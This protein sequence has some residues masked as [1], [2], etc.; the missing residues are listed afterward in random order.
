MRRLTCTQCLVQPEDRLYEDFLHLGE[1]I[2]LDHL[3]GA[4]EYRR[5]DFEAERLGGFKVD[6]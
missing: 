6:D 3:V 1:Y 4:S 2:L 5:R